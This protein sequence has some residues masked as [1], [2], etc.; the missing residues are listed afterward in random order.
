MPCTSSTP[1]T[2]RHRGRQEKIFKPRKNDSSNCL[3]KEYEQTRELRKCLGCDRRH[4]RAGCESESARRTD[5]EDRS[6]PEETR[7]D[8]GRSGAPLR[9]N[10]ATDQRSAPGAGLAL[11]ARLAGQH[12]DR[13][14]L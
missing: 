1:S 5:A 3:E 12:R 11:L 7:L 14:G 13:A 8:A 4:P 9:R 10:T 6:T 2:K